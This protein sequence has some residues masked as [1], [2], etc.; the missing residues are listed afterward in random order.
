M[1]NSIS[2]DL[3]R[4]HIDTIILRT[5]S[6]TD[7][8]SQEIIDE[9]S[10][11]SDGKYEL[12]QATLY[13]SLKRLEN[14]KYITAYWQDSPE[15]GRRRFFHLT[16][17]GHALMTRNLNDW[18]FSR[19]IINTLV[20]ASDENNENS[21]EKVVYRDVIVEKPVEKI[22]YRDV[23]VEKPVEKIV[24][25][26]VVVEKEVKDTVKNDESYTHEINFR[27]ILNG[28]IKSSQ[29]QKTKKVE[30]NESLSQ[31]PAIINQNI[32]KID[33]K[34]AEF[35]SE[36]NKT[37]SAKSGNTDFSDLIDDCRKE[38]IKVR[39]SRKSVTIANAG[40]KIY[41]VTAFSS[42]MVFVLIALEFL[43]LKLVYKD[44]L[45]KWF[46][47]TL[48]VFAIFPAVMVFRAVNN[49]KKVIYRYLSVK[50][51]LLTAL[52][53][54]F[55]LALLNV[56]VVFLAGIDLSVKA[57]LVKSVVIPAIIYANSFVY[58]VIRC[59]FVSSNLFK[60]VKQ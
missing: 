50:N 59:F 35:F 11:K 17:K 29:E 3:I 14:E 37:N 48:P 54:I 9:I 45:S 30:D 49:P 18:T 6:E 22:V 12:K 15:G 41:S 7:K 40:L 31:N 34:Q 1:E 19:A 43:L 24:E 55:D 33:D 16:E 32:D 20:D 51:I 53:I 27:T 38:D 8:N 46:L 4:G 28:L 42:L 44:V 23:I 10:E 36:I 26:E 58:F 57:N 13:S 21:T 52:I 60:V 47:I 25:K 5:I 39:V 56:A 2:S